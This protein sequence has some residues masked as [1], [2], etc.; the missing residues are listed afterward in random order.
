[1][2]RQSSRGGGVRDSPGGSADID[3]DGISVQTPQSS[4]GSPKKP[5][6]R[7]VKSLSFVEQDDFELDVPD[8]PD[9]G[10]EGES[11]HPY[12]AGGGGRM[13]ERDGDIEDLSSR[14]RNIASCLTLHGD[15]AQQAAEDVDVTSADDVRGGASPTAAAASRRGLRFSSLY[16]SRSNDTSDCAVRY[17]PLRVNDYDRS[18]TVLSNGQGVIPTLQRPVLMGTKLFRTS[19]DLHR[20]LSAGVE[21]DDLVSAFRSVQQIV[22]NYRDIK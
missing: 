21:A 11:K 19:T 20:Y 3:D 2:S 17:S 22:N 6:L 7:L 18:A 10:E 4:S 1:M 5:A 14:I 8:G 13:G 15:G 16:R 12:S 9:D